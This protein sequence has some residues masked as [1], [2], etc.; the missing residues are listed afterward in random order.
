MIVNH[1]NGD[2][3]TYYP[4]VDRAIRA[5]RKQGIFVLGYTSTGYGAR[6]PK[7]IRQ[8]IDAVYQLPGRWHVLRFWHIVHGMSADQLQA[9][10]ELAK[11]RNAGP[12]RDELGLV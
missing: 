4:N 12:F 11:Q 3:E 2:D 8:K 9:A 10:L 6:D 5:T 7:I 1:S